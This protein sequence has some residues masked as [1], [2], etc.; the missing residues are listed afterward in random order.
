M[1]I[2]RDVARGVLI[3]FATSLVLAGG[4]LFLLVCLT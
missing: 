3:D 2:D 1:V 4:G